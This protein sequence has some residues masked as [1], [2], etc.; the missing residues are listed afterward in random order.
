MLILRS[1]TVLGDGY[2]LWLW[3]TLWALAALALIYGSRMTVSWLIKEYAGIS[4]PNL[5]FKE[6]GCSARTRCVLEIC[7]VGWFA[8][9]VIAIILSQTSHAMPLWVA[10]ALIGF[11][12]MLALID[13]QTCM[14]PNELNL[15]VI[16][17]GLAWQSY[18][19]EDHWPDAQNLWAMVIGYV[20]PWA[21]NRLV[22]WWHGRTCYVMGM[23]DAKLLAGLGVWLGIIN[24][25]SVWLIACQAVLVYVLLYWVLRR[26]WLGSVAFA[27]FLA[28][29]VSV[30]VVGAYV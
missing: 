3:S 11:L 30:V 27:P 18:C 14:L 21:M 16:V 13:A 7:F 1:F 28:F 26:K 6:I 12:G 22:S 8:A 24:L 15:L 4:V 17:S 2:E 9:S 20:I 25:G 19:S 29:G 23:G 5:P 10:A